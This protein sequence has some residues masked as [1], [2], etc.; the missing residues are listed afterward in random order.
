MKTRIFIIIFS[1]ICVKNIFA[2][3]IT[4]AGF[5][6][7]FD[8]SRELSNH[9]SY[10]SY[11]FGAIKPYYSTEGPARALY[12]YAE[13]GLSFKVTDKLSFTNSYVYERQQP[14]ETNSRNE[15]RLFQQLTLKL[16]FNKFSLKQR[17]RFDERFI[18]NNQTNSFDFS[19]RLRYLLGGSYDFNDNWYL[20]TYSEFFFN[21]TKGADFQFNENWSALQIGYNISKKHAIEIG[22]LFVGWMN[23]SQNNWFNQH[24][25]Q[26]T[27]VSKL[28][29]NKHQ[30][31]SK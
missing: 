21:T 30:I 10:N 19:H 4:I 3:N 7:T 8:H 28:N 22:Y 24:Y 23:D 1:I 13:N 26:T 5:F 29:F 31:N 25:L 6:P 14:F 11:L 27:W 20:M 17:L 16:P 2:Q 9:F 15:H 18:Q 12:L